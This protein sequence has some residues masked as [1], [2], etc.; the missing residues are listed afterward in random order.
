MISFKVTPKP[1]NLRIL[2]YLVLILLCTCMKPPVAQN[3]TIHYYRYAQD[4]GGW[5][6]WLWIPDSGIDA[7]SLDFEKVD[8]DGFSTI[9]YTPPL[10]SKTERGIIIRKS[11]ADNNWA[12]KDVMNDRYI[13]VHANEIWIVQGDEK[14]YN[15]KPDVSKP[16]VQF[17]VMDSR[18]TVVVSLLTPPTDYTK[19]AVYII[20]DNSKDGTEKKLL[21]T[22]FGGSS[23]TDVIIK[24]AEPVV[25]LSHQYIVRDES[26]TF[27][28]APVMLRGILDTFAYTGNDLGLTV[29]SASRS[30][31]DVQKNKKGNDPSIY[32]ADFAV[33]APTAKSVSVALYKNAGRYNKDGIVTNNN[34]CTLYEM[35]RDNANG[36]WRTGIM[37]SKG[38]L[39]GKYYLYKVEFAD[40]TTI[41]A[42]D[43]YAR[44]V[45]ANG[46][47]AA[48]TDLNA[49]NPPRWD[50]DIKPPFAAMQDAVIYETHIRDFS[51]ASDSGMKHKGK[52]LAFS[53]A[54]LYNSNGDPIGIEHLKRLG[55]THVHLLPSFDFAS[56]DETV[57]DKKFSKKE[58]Y[59][60]GYDPLHY[61]VPEGSYSSE[62]KN[63]ATR[64]REFKLLVQ[65]LHAAGIRV[66]MDVV[67]NHTYSAADNPF[68]IVPGYYYRQDATGALANGSG[69]G[70]E[71]ASERAMVRKF[72]VDS[73]VYWAREYHVDGFRFDLMGLIDTDTMV[74]VTNA[75]R[76]IDPTSLIYGEPW[77]AGGSPLPQSMQTVK[78][79][80]KNLEFAVFNDNIRGAIKGDSDSGKP[81]FITGAEN[82]ETG[83][84]AGVQG[85]IDEFTASASESINYVTAHDNLNLYDKITAS[86]AEQGMRNSAAK[87]ENKNSVNEDSVMAAVKLA[88]GIV[89]TSQG[90]PFFQAGD[91]FCRTKYGDANSY[92]SGDSINAIRWENVTRYKNVVDYYAGLISLRKE[93]P[94]FRMDSAQS[95]KNNISIITAADHLVAFTLNNNAN[96]DLW[97]TIFIAYNGGSTEKTLTLP[98]TKTNSDAA[99][100]DTDGK[101][102]GLANWHQVVDANYAGTNV[103]K[104]ITGNSITLP[105]VSMAV[106]YTE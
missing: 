34:K 40:G 11:T 59:N 18:D 16:P 102:Q 97:R 95:I 46:R 104:D 8:S 88:N 29:H 79:A 103:L 61:N 76:N 42:V 28:D 20:A 9:T 5:N 55:I 33:W 63:P 32:A 58:K 91:E 84:V 89:L 50:A 60:W 22:A 77:Q 53:E 43:P 25:E 85:A 7:V 31:G 96:G 65:A 71:V 90:I 1:K 73:C 14:M 49:S 26:G 48:I 69:C 24:L 66:V 80:Q 101:N 15:Q 6:A 36:V 74:A 30:Q 35:Q 4:Y 57:V 98:D 93:H 78:G 75:V 21:G 27:S 106:L 51:I 23:A 82:C 41:Y 99:Q 44:A 67:Y 83:I 19:F 37:Q 47:R 87:N 10:F 52:F 54:G 72:I 62:T 70:N 3:I 81:G 86:L 2:L 68:G 92:A 17:A 38:S 12:A 13:D 94:S 100:N 105:P 39:E 64:I 56:I 45:S